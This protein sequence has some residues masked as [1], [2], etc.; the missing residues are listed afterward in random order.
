[1]NGNKI[2]RR[3]FAIKMAASGAIMS[4]GASALNCS[5]KA[6]QT[7]VALQLYTV[8]ELL[9]ND[10]RGTVEKVAKIGYDAVEFAG[11]GGLSAPE[12]KQLLKTNGLQV[13]GTHE[14]FEGLQSNTEETIAFNLGIGNKNIVVPSMPGAMRKNGADGIKEFAAE[15]NKIGAKVHDAGMQLLYHNHSFEF[16]AMDGGS[17]Y[18]ILLKNTDANLVK[19]EI[20]VAWAQRGGDNPADLI[21]KE[22]SRVKMLHMKDFLNDGNYTLVPV[23]TGVVDMSSIIKAAREVGVQWFVVEQDSMKR[24]PLEAIEISLKNMRKLLKQ[25]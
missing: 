19:L 15:M 5:N 22:G 11:Y 23:G 2:T 14:G 6:T 24:P 4:L 8:R 25:A 18:E 3:D 12:V 17:I 10:F 9:K 21:R 16:E 20:D 13:A 1:M 7:P